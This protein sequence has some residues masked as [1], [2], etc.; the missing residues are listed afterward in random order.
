MKAVA[1]QVLAFFLIVE[2]VFAET[3]EVRIDDRSTSLQ[4]SLFPDY[5]NTRSAA[6]DMRWVRANDSEL[7]AFWEQDGRSVLETIA[8]F[9]G[10]RWREDD[11]DIHIVRFFPTAGSAKPLIIPLGGI[12][13]GALTEALPGGARMKLNLIYQLAHRNLAQE[14]RVEDMFQP[15]LATH[16]LMQPGPYRRDNLAM[17]LTLV[18]AQEVL[19][20]DS[21]YDA[22]QS[23]FW[24][25]RTP[26]R[27]ILE[28]YLLSE[29]ILTTGR[30]LVRWV[31]E[32]P[33]TSRLV[34]ATRLPRR[35]KQSGPLKQRPYVEG[36]PLKGLLGFSVRT[37]ESNF[38]VVD[39]IDIFRLAYACGL[40][41]GDII[42][43]VDNA[44]PRNHRSLIERIL[45]TLDVGGATVQVQRDGQDET[46]ILQPLDL[47]FGEDSDYWEYLEDS[48]F[49]EKE[50]PQDSVGDLE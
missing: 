37:N 48:L 46:V 32:E 49:Y 6:A 29:W 40:R 9:S 14:E 33:I 39:K 15:S 38:L 19:G 13:K 45:S 7:V 30:P 17:L 44:R 5:Y 10:V 36:L 16:P 34:A 1:I 47:G 35:V 11:L 23:A 31:E 12:R 27:Q 41:E 24:K 25:Q 50:S 20:L 2:G 26:G 28:Q 18:T 22:Y 8:L 43:R 3:P 21:T 4:A 42:R